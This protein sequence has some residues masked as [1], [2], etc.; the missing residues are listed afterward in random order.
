[1][2]IS[3][4]ERLLREMCEHVGIHDWWNAVQTQHVTVDDTIVG[5][6]YTEDIDPPSILICINLGALDAETSAMQY[7]TL[8]ELNV[9]LA[10][11]QSGYFGIHPTEELWVYMARVDLTRTLNGKW[12]ADFIALQIRAAQGIL[13]ATFSIKQ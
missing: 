3:T 7:R 9:L 11:G 6:I 2:T 1:M 10:K 8:L 12:L 5:L 4:Y 13:E